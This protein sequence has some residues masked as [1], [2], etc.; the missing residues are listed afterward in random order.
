MLGLFDQD[1]VHAICNVVT[2]APQVIAR[3]NLNS[4]RFGIVL[5]KFDLVLSHNVGM[6][7]ENY[8]PGRPE[9]W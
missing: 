9:M 5:R 3:L 8:K 4:P 7:V 6:T 2:P 1:H